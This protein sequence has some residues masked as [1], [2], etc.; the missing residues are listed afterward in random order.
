M[1]DPM[2]LSYYGLKKQ[3]FHV[4]PDPELLYLSPSHAKALAAITDGIEERKGFIAVTGDAGVGK[5]TVLRSYLRLKKGEPLKTVY[6]FNP[7][8]T[9]EG[10]LKTIYRELA[11]ST[12]GA[13]V[14]EMVDRLREV[15]IEESR[16]GYTVVLFIDE[17]QNMP[18][19]TLESLATMSESETSGERLLQVVLVGQPEFKK[20]LSRL[21]HLKERLTVDATIRPLSRAESLGYLRFRLK[22]AGTD[23]ASVFTAS[24]LRKIAGTSKGIPR[25]LNIL[26]DNALVRGFS[27]QEKPVTRATVKEIVRSFKGQPRLLER[28]LPLASIL[29]P[30]IRSFAGT[31]RVPSIEQRGPVHPAQ[32]EEDDVI[33]QPPAAREG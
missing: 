31:A 8:L 33:V 24:A 15:L 6:V 5:T 11:L 20:T 9:F 3:P 28:R 32:R 17:A 4:T 12:A 29:A 19:D 13:S 22:H 18:A 27:R 16:K 10:L 21:R 1:R 2:Y 26:S 23:F 7:R 30:G 25:V 14:A